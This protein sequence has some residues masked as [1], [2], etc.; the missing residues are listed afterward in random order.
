VAVREY[1]GQ[2]GGA[3]EEVKLNTG[4]VFAALDSLKKEKKGDKG[5]AI[6]SSSRKKHGEGA[7]QRQEPSQKE[8]F[9]APAPLTTK[10]WA[11]VEDDDDYC[12][13]TTSPPRP[14]WGTACEPAKEE[15]D[16]DDVVRAALQ[17]VYF[18]TFS[19]CLVICLWNVPMKCSYTLI[20]FVVV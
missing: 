17:E 15:D 3:V 8:M 12:F 1:G 16:V 11:D 10:S 18:S 6:G 5:K 7:A 14:V 4:N 2:R 20:L 19:M 9:W 13:T